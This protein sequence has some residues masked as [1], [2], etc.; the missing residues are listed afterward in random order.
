MKT[1]RIFDTTLRDGEQGI[2]YLLNNQQKLSVLERLTKLDV[3]V[4]ELGMVTDQE[5]QDLFE[6]AALVV[7]DK[8]IAALCRLND[9]EIQNTV[10]AL[11]RFKHATINLLCV[12][13]EIHLNKK[14]Q[15]SSEDIYAL[16]ERSLARIR[17]A[18]FHGK[19][20]AILE[21]SSRGSETLLHQQIQFLINNGVRDICLA[22]TVGAMAPARS[23]HFFSTFISAYPEV[24]FSAHFHNDLGLA[25]ANTISAIDAGVYE[26]QVTL[27]GIGE[28]CGNASFEEVMAVLSHCDGY[29]GKV[30]TGITLKDVVGMCQ[31]FY[32]TIDKEPNANKPIIGSNAFSTCAGIHQSAIVK[33]PETYEFINPN[34]IGLQRNFHIN[35]LSSSKVMARYEH[36][37]YK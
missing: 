22:D 3:A 24:R 8:N 11:K 16:L 21:D 2:G 4:I 20:Y 29:K 35:R 28:R 19:I 7:G 33:D 27:G 36:I 9:V 10:K 25:V 37:N 23:Y 12:G 15:M 32:T 30:S 13:S 18:E 5:S 34:S 1:I 31:F 26:V 6:E 17:E 14:M